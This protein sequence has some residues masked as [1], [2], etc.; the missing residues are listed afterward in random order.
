MELKTDILSDAEV[1][2]NFTGDRDID[3]TIR[4]LYNS[5]L[6]YVGRFVLNNSGD[7][8]DAEDIFQEV[9]VAFI[10]LVKKQKFRGE[11]SIKTFL[12]SLN[13]NMWLNEL[14]RRSRAEA[15]ETK[16]EKEK[17]DSEVATSIIENRE[18]NDQ[19]MKVMDELGDTC[20]KILI[21]Y[22]YGNHSIKEI[23]TELPYENE[24]VVR[25]KKHKCL[26]K[27]QEMLSQN[28]HLYNQL[29]NLLHE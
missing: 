13:R 11:A 25:N 29:K 22:Y 23:L 14:K 20:K 1:I 6:E 5:Y 15:R 16:F 24:Q 7:R 9:L 12:F 27:L 28:K 3:K 2:A 21:L 18:A 10:H 17:E 4:F 19:L 26:K 8:Q